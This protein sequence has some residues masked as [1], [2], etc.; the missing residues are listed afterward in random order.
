VP[1]SVRPSYSFIILGIW[2]CGQSV[3][4][5]DD[6]ISCQEFVERLIKEAHTAMGSLKPLFNS[7]L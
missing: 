3:A 7:P 4:L 2:N 6:I 5:I 1:I